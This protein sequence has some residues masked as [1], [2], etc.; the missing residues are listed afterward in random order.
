MLFLFADLIIVS[1][2]YIKKYY[3][4]RHRLRSRKIHVVPNYVNDNKFKPDVKKIKYKD[5]IVYIGRLSEE[6]NLYHLID[7]LSKTNIKL[8]IIGFGI[9]ANSIKRK[10]NKAKVEVNLLGNIKNENLPGLLN[11]YKYFILPSKFEGMPKTLLEA[12]SCG[13]ACVGSNI[14]GIR[15]IIDDGE[16]GILCD[17]SIKGIR[18]AILLLI[19][20]NKLSKK[21]GIKARESIASAYSLEFCADKELGLYKTLCLK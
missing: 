18:K 12:M 2:P 20:N 6:K 4:K 13:L 7:A 3:K 16:N 5:K 9:L 17:T 15:D 21:I 1:A 19:N 14:A 10:A 8:D 11:K